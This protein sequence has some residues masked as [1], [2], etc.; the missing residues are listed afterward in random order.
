MRRPA[1][2]TLT[3]ALVVVP[4]LAVAPPAVAASPTSTVTTSD[5]ALRAGETATV[6]I[7]FSEP[8]T[9]FDNADVQ[10]SGGTISAFAGNAVTQTA[11]FTPAPGFEGTATVRVDN[12]GVTGS[13]PLP[14]TGVSQVTMAV[15]TLGPTVTSFVVA[16]AL[17]LA[18]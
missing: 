16:D 17:L 1:V 11:V 14:G 9:G 3:L 13:G 4:L 7:T 15:D 5:A 6:T 8:V 12:S 18:G 2:V 10:V